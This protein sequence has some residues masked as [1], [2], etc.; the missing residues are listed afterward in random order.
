MC[1]TRLGSRPVVR[2][3]A[4]PGRSSSFEIAWEMFQIESVEYGPTPHAR[5]SQAEQSIPVL[6]ELP[7]Q[8]NGMFSIDAARDRISPRI[9][10]DGSATAA[11]KT[12]AGRVDCSIASGPFAFVG[13]AVNVASDERSGMRKLGHPS[14][15]AKKS[16]TTTPSPLFAK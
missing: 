15:S 1:P 3:S 7:P 4:S 9:V 2:L 10:R 16:T 6:V 12:G 13:S 11:S 14:S 5:L 8:R